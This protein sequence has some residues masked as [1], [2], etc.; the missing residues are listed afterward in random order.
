VSIS[1]SSRTHEPV[2]GDAWKAKFDE[3]SVAIS[4]GTV[5]SLDPFTIRPMYGQP[6]DFF[7]EEEQATLRDS[8]GQLGQV[9]D[10]I[11]RKKDPVIQSQDTI[12]TSRD[13][14]ARVWR[15]SETSLEICDGERR[16]RAAMRSGLDTIRAKVIEIDDNGA[17]LVAAVSNFNRVAHTTL[18]RAK[19][20]HRLLHG[21]P[22][23]PMHVICTMQGISVATGQ[24]LLQTLTLPDDIQSMM[25]PEHL[26]KGARLLGKVPGYELSRLTK[27]P[28]LVGHARQLASSYVAGERKLPE[29]RDEVDRVLA[30]FGAGRDVIAERYQ[31]ARR[32][33]TAE[34]K[35]G[36]ALQH[37][38]SARDYIADLRKEG[39]LPETSPTLAA[40]LMKIRSIADDALKTIGWDA[41]SK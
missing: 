29:L 38:R 12:L 23:L 4:K 10:I 5:L 25:N 26:P 18:E 8:L 20:I 21:N 6:R 40:S 28:E 16:W 41:N 11:V 7:P 37:I 34:S 19:S 3:I 15:L 24:K 2:S 1:S 17:Y 32:L 14:N 39:S 31:P 30:A 27:K 36:V 13:P 9:Q 22:P 35:V 33:R